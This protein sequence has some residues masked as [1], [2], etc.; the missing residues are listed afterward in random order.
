MSTFLDPRTK[1]NASKKKKK[2]KFE[3]N[4]VCKMGEIEFIYKK[5][6][7]SR[8]PKNNKKKKKLDNMLGARANLNCIKKFTRHKI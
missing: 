3:I 2:K 7:Q 4:N 8:S 6:K 5:R 1:I